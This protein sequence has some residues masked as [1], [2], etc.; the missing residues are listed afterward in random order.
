MGIERRS[1]RRLL[2]AALT[3][4]AATAASPSPWRLSDQDRR[5]LEQV[6][7]DSL[8]GHLSFLASDALGGRTT[9]SPGQ[10]IAAEYIAAQF[11]RAALEPLGLDG[12]FQNAPAR[13]ATPV[14]EGFRFR[15]AAPERTVEVPAETFQLTTV[16]GLSIAEA[17]VV[18]LPPGPPGSVEGVAGRVVLTDFDD[19][20]GGPEAF[21]QRQHWVR[22]LRAGHPALVVVLSR[23]L[24]VPTDYFSTPVLI[25]PPS[26]FPLPGRL[27]LT[28]SPEL[29][30]LYRALPV[31]RPAARATLSVPEPRIEET[32]LRNVAGLLRGSDPAL[33]STYFLLSAHYDGTGEQPGATGPDRIWN[34][35][36][37]DGSGTTALLELASALGTL[38]P[39][40]RR[41]IVFIAFFGEEKG[42]RGARY[43]ASH[44]LVPLASTVALL[45]LE[46]LGRTDSTEGRSKA[47]TASL[48]GFAYST[49]GTVLEAAGRATGVEVYEDP[50]R[51]EAF[52]ASSDNYPL[53]AAGVVAHTLCVVF[54]DFED[55]HQPGDEW[56]KIDFENMERTVRL[57]GAAALM[58]ADASEPPR[59]TDAPGAGPF[60]EAWRRLRED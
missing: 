56:R 60:A 14:A 13:I 8:R 30:E 24:P 23:A 43:Y 34:A 57:A 26:A 11:R 32:R 21:R 55:Y 52:F 7:A 6:S 46:H 45:N 1:R 3:F 5:A 44:P 4:L 19:L 53:A 40:P 2:A 50:R 58:V 18:K 51:S 9:P 31:G 47:G 20:P 39:R 38:R 15:V 17:E 37:D 33:A 59:W 41:S 35:A 36:N 27:V 42:L 48:T 22:A 28:S 25:E 16:E 54:E 49:L 29:A 10:E 12:Y